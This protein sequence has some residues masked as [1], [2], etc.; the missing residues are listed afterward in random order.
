MLLL[1]LDVCVPVGDE[2]D[3][4]VDDGVPDVE[5]ADADDADE[6][7]EEDDAAG[8]VVVRRPRVD[9]G[10]LVTVWVVGALLVELE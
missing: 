9:D 1:G 10:E 6:E 3:V 8:E 5:D 2:V 4:E 7:V